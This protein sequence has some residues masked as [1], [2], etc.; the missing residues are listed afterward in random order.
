MSPST[1]QSTVKHGQKRRWRQRREWETECGSYNPVT[2][3]IS[4]RASVRTP[5]A[6]RDTIPS[7]DARPPYRLWCFKAELYEKSSRCGKSR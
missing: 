3:R 5:I 4:V 6:T 2:I 1:Y 7:R